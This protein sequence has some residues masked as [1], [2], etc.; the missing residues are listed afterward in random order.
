MRHTR[1]EYLG[2][3]LNYHLIRGMKPDDI[4]EHFRQLAKDRITI[5]ISHRFST[6]RRADHICVLDHGRLLEQG[7]HESL[8][9]AGGRYAQ[10][11]LLQAARFGETAQ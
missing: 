11:F 3:R 8:L 7:D 2:L 10:L 9:A 5:L 6:V 4:F 1:L